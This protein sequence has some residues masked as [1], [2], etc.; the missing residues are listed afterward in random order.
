MPAARL[1]LGYEC[2]GD[3]N[4]GIILDRRARAKALEDAPCAANG[5][6]SHSY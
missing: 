6:G 2:C 4:T 1:E 5:Y 3:C